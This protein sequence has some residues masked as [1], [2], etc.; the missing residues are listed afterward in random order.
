MY[1]QQS[2][3]KLSK[4]YSKLFSVAIS[5][6]RDW[7]GLSLSSYALSWWLKHFFNASHLE[8][9]KDNEDISILEKKKKKDELPSTLYIQKR[10]PPVPVM[11]FLS[12]HAVWISKAYPN[13]IL[14]QC[15]STRNELNYLTTKTNK[16]SGCFRPCLIHPMA[17]AF[18]GPCVNN[19]LSTCVLL[20]TVTCET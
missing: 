9:Q 2:T 13:T 12:V 6:G 15:L 3:G 5:G 11:V 4:I 8:S 7:C 1:K 18:A 14:C 20:L 17:F 10:S 19:L 16:I